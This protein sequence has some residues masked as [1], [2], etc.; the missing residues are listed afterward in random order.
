MVVVVAVLVVVVVVVVAVVVVAVSSSSSST[1]II[2]HN[3]LQVH[4]HVR[5]DK[6]RHV[7]IGVSHTFLDHVVYRPQSMQDTHNNARSTHVANQ[8]NNI[9][10]RGGIS[11]SLWRV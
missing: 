5:E 9:P 11:R 1:T 3:R 4:H 8:L 2:D 6:R 7:C 10:S